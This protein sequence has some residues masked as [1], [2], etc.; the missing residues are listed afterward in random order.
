MPVVQNLIRGL[1]L[2]VLL[3][4]IAATSQGQTL[5]LDEFSGSGFIDQAVWRLP[6]AGPGSFLGRTQLKTDFA[7][8]YPVRGSGVA[9][10]ELETFL[11]STG[12][13]FLGNEINT[14]R[15]FAR[16]G[17]L[18]FEVRMRLRDIPPGLV[19]A[20]FLFDVQ[21]NNAG[22]QLVRDEYDHEILTSEALP[23]RENR[24][25][26]NYWNDKPFTGPDSGGSAVYLEP[27]IAGGWDLTQF[28]DYRID[29]LEDRLDW[30]VDGQ[31]VRTASNN[32]PD[33]PMTLRLNLWAP[34]ADFG[35]AYSAALQPAT[36]P[37]DNETFGLELDRIEIKR[38]NTFE[39]GNLLAEPGFENQGGWTFFNNASLSS[40]VARSGSQSLRAF[41]P[42]SGGPNASGAYQDVAVQ[43]GDEL[44]ARVFARSDSGD[45][46]AGTSNFATIKI[47]FLDANDNVLGANA[48]ES[49]ICDGR[50]PDF[51]ENVWVE[52]VVNAV[53]PA[54]AAKARV[55]LPII[56]LNNQ[57]GSVAW[58]DAVLVKLNG[59]LLGDANQDGDLNNLDI[60]SFVMAL[61]N[62][63]AYL[64]AHPGV[65][66]DLV[67][68]MNSDGA[69]NNLD[70]FPFVQ[71]L[72]F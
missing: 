57:G 27:A 69:L 1:I 31:L 47:E 2:M 23:G 58:D 10:L 13:A 67:L 54:N 38:L 5:V 40:S 24:L 20:V 48:K 63:P 46:I 64:V 25:L 60:A 15:N 6:A 51:P 7:T 36:E 49:V 8:G 44:E 43:P 37:G 33:D 66:P 68:D 30:Y 55:V 19:G 28:H 18:R 45:S 12:T 50:D 41:G 72:G 42:F 39:S 3:T 52:G 56:Q 14:K 53:V 34:A 32:I 35:L 65:D 17:G 61:F 29:W 21:R 16:A 70:I 9:T 71:S 26:L 59:F 11:D 22:G 62:R 4:A